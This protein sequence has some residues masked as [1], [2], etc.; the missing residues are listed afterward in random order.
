M[1]TK[2]ISVLIL[3]ALVLWGLYAWLFGTSPGLGEAPIEAAQAQAIE[4]G[5]I[6]YPDMSQRRDVPGPGSGE[7][8]THGE[9][10]FQFFDIEGGPVPGIEVLLSAR[11]D[12]A[13]TAAPGTPNTYGLASEDDGLARIEGVLPG[14]FD[15]QLV[16]PGKILSREEGELEVVA[17]ETVI[18]RIL[19]GTGTVVIGR[20][21]IFS[22]LALPPHIR[23]L[24]RGGGTNTGEPEG[25]V[26]GSKDGTFLIP[27]TPGE[28][29]ICAFWA[30]ANETYVIAGKDVLIE[31]GVNDV[32]VLEVIDSQVEVSLAFQYQ[33][34]DVSRDELFAA[35]TFEAVLNINSQNDRSYGQMIWVSLDQDPV[36]LGLWEG[37][38]V[39]MLLIG[40]KFPEMLDGYELIDQQ[41]TVHFRSPTEHVTLT[42]EVTRPVDTSLT[43]AWSGEPFEGEFYFKRRGSDPPKGTSLRMASDEVGNLRLDKGEYDY[44]LVRDFVKDERT[45][46]C[47]A[48]TVQ[49]TGDPITI[50]ASP[51][52]IL[53]GTSEPGKTVG[54]SIVGFENWLMFRARAREDGSWEIPGIPLDR[55]LLNKKQELPTG[56]SPNRRISF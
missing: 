2:S 12:S 18:E 52:A 44:V 50:E 40:P 11:A 27:C 9:I 46:A 3:L 23:L 35:G 36:I 8:P 38:W 55:V 22:T 29:Y 19:V 33:G 51:G 21:P 42:Y 4:E 53:C 5:P 49:I 15:W 31:K 14:R 1:T 28:G 43:I 56:S 41:P 37:D 10:E 26:Y 13:A 54:Y 47:A 17:G 7:K 20:V 48:G 45:N 25:G 39:F 6:S 30:E 34:Q 32:G 16:A 24:K